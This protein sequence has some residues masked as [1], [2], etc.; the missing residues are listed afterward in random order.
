MRTEHPDTKTQRH[1]QTQPDTT[2]DPNTTNYTRRSRTQ[3]PETEHDH[4]YR[5]AGN[6]LH[7]THTHTMHPKHTY[8]HKHPE[9]QTDTQ[10][11]MHPD[12]RHA[13]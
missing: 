7:P 3:A 4:E 10:T 11:N 9:T 6:Q 8:T 2:E 12:S 5:S 13:V 1:D